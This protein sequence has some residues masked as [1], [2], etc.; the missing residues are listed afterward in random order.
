MEKQL[1]QSS[2]KRWSYDSD[3]QKEIPVH[4]FPCRLT[5]DKLEKLTDKYLQHR[6]FWENLQPVYAYFE[7]NRTIPVIEV[8][9]TG[10]Y[11]IKP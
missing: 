5:E 7:K 4:I 6:H 10:R 2:N 1:F 3:G 8:N 9:E 11:R